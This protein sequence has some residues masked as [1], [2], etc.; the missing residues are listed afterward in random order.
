MPSGTS[1]RP[2]VLFHGLD[3]SLAGLLSEM[4]ADMGF[5]S[6]F[7]GPELLR[8]DVVVVLVDRWEDAGGLIGSARAAHAAPVVAL[9][10]FFDDDLKRQA[11]VAGADECCSLGEPL[12][13]LETVLQRIT[14][15]AR[16]A[17]SGGPAGGSAS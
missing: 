8:P 4:L 3:E 9:V 17:G 7:S 12:E 16:E 14:G 10:P 2:R 5:E 15:Q 1:L 6:G 13:A 11:L